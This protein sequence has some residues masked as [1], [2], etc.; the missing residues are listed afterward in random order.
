MALCAAG[1][2]GAGSVARAQRAQDVG[3]KVR[4]EGET[5]TVR[6]CMAIGVQL[7]ELCQLIIGSLQR[8][9]MIVKPAAQHA[10]RR[11]CGARAGRQFHVGTE[12]TKA[13]AELWH[14]VVS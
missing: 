12:H 3:I 14:R 6:L 9:A 1:A 7:T 11:S 10:H 4:A 13:Y 2:G 5:T 8:V